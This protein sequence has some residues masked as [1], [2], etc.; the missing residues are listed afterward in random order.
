[1]K[2]IQILTNKSSDFAKHKY[3]E[4]GSDHFTLP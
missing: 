3:F 1:M 2:N 4:Q